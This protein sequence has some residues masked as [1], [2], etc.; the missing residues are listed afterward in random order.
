MSHAK[1]Q[2]EEDFDNRWKEFANDMLESFLVQIKEHDH[3]EQFL[4]LLRRLIEDIE[5]EEFSQEI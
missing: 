2:I 3:P 1:R 4:I 5:E